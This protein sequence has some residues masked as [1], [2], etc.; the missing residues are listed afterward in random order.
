MGKGLSGGR[1]IV[2]PS[3][4]AAFAPEDNVIIGNVAFF[5]ATSGEG[6]IGG[7]AGERFGVRNS[8]AIVVVEGVGDHGCEYMT[9]GTALI[10]GP[11]GRNFAAGM[12]GGIAYVYDPEAGLASKLGSH[13][14]ELL[15]PDDQDAAL[16]R[17]LMESHLKHTASPLAR[18]LLAAFDPA[19]FVKAIPTAYRKAQ[20]A[21][22]AAA[23]EDEEARLLCAY[24]AVTA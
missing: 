5:G 22:A 1:I 8:G 12:T 10:L 9:G 18:R 6:F 16:I 7:L 4:G 24:E 14:V 3:A 11:V 21:Y 23:G 13:A 17:R 2:R 15:P 19:A 20:E